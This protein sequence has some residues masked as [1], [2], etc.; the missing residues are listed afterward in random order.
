[1]ITKKQVTSVEVVD[2]V[3][4]LNGEVLSE[5]V[6]MVG[7]ESMV[8]ML[9]VFLTEL[10]EGLITLNQCLVPL[11]GDDLATL[12]EDDFNGIALQ[13]HTLKSCAGSFGALA[14]FEAVKRLEKLAKEKNI[15]RVEQQ[16]VKVNELSL[17]TA[18]GLKLYF[19]ESE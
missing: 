8:K 17:L 5:L 13:A 2:E 14:L 11:K 6:D 9:Q 18:N 19:M 4:L 12:R 16:L 10:E 15:E 3:S 7:K 1:M